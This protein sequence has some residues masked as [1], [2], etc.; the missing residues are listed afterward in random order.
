[1]KKQFR[2]ILADPENQS[3][4]GQARRALRGHPLPAAPPTCLIESAVII[5]P[6]GSKWLY[7]PLAPGEETS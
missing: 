5:Q 4:V 2:E 7:R 3:S 6:D 1:V